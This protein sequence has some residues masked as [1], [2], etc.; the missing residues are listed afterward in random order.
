MTSLSPLCPPAPPRLLQAGDAGRQV[1]LVVHH[2]HLLRRDLQ[3]LAER[4]HGLAA[5][6]HEAHRLQEPQRH[7]RDRDAAGLPL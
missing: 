7:A 2:E 4:A 1:E 6:V 5:A 3:V